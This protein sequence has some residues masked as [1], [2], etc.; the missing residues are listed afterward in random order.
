MKKSKRYWKYRCGQN[1]KANNNK[2]NGQPFG[3]GTPTPT[4]WLMMLD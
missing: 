2:N 1:K 3:E 4:S